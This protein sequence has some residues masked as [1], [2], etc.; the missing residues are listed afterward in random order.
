MRH[1]RP[2]SIRILGFLLAPLLAASTASAT[3]VPAGV[4][5]LQAAIDAASPGDHLVLTGGTYVGPVVVNKSLR[6]SCVGAVP[7]FIDANCEAPVALDVAADRVR[8]ES[9]GYVSLSVLRGA[10]TQ[11]RI[12]DHHKVELRASIVATVPE[13]SPCGTEQTGIEVSGTSSHVKVVG[14]LSYDS[15]GA[16]ILLSGL[17]AGANVKIKKRLSVDNGAGIAIQHSASG[18]KAGAAGIIIDQATLVGNGIGVDVV[19]SDG[20][21]IKR[22]L[23]TRGDASPPLTGIS[24]DATSDGNRVAKCTSDSPPQ[25]LVYSDTGTDNCGQHNQSVALTP[26]S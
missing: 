20:I 1:C 4:G 10:T 8:V 26:C 6:V 15:P 24:F 12:A 16:G 19:D 22:S 13:E 14:A 2:S 11:V 3:D 18:A 17:A 21:R 23:L 7:C 5:T 25:P 9:R